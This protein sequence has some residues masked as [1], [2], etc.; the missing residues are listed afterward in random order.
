MNFN[1]NNH[2]NGHNKIREKDSNNVHIKLIYD[3]LLLFMSFLTVKSTNK[4]AKNTT[5]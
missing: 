2:I 4:K 1:K 5:N 3:S